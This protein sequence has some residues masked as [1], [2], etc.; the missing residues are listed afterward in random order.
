MKETDDI[1]VSLMNT[2][3]SDL[4]HQVSLLR[5][6]KASNTSVTDYSS[7]FI[8]AENLQKLC[9]DVFVALNEK[10]YSKMPIDEIEQS[11]MDFK[12]RITTTINTKADYHRNRY[13]STT[14]KSLSILN[15]LTNTVNRI[16]GHVINI[17]NDYLKK[18]SHPIADDTR[19]EPPRK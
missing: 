4:E 6:M 8:A 2:L 13:F 10:K 17:Q 19:M 7:L 11:I 1:V 14:G 5:S 9:L 18:Q 16:Q 12:E 3:K 15:E